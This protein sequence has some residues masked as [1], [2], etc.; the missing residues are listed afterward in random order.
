MKKPVDVEIMGQKLV[1]RSDEEEGYVR[2][3]ADYVDD[4]MQEVIKGS[5]SVGKGNVAVLA[6]LNIADDYHRLKERYD[7]VLDRMD[8]WSKRLAN[9]LT[10]EG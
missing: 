4:K 6:A 5:Q 2:R 8:R 3:V 7:E 1:L 10:K 9:T